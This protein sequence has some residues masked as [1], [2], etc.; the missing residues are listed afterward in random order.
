MV[1][2]SSLLIFCLLCLVST[3]PIIIPTPPVMVPVLTDQQALEER[4]DRCPAFVLVKA[5]YKYKSYVCF[6]SEN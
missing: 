2:A 3:L 5:Y 6:L 4:I 1:L